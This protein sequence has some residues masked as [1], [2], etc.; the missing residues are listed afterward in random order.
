MRTHH[1][2]FY[3][4]LFV[5]A[6]LA[7]VMATASGLWLELHRP[8]GSSGILMFLVTAVAIVV[9]VEVIAGL[10]GDWL[11]DRLHTRRALR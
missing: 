7:I 8:I 6:V 2:V 4:A 3:L 10:F 5:G 9:G 11:D 1:A